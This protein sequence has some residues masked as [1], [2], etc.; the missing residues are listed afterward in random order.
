MRIL[1]STPTTAT[2]TATAIGL[3]Q[4]RKD[5]NYRS[6]INLTLAVTLTIFTIFESGMI[7][8]NTI[9]ARVCC[10]KLHEIELI[11]ALFEV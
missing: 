2:A 11:M 3:Q 10:F 5:P 1:R 9:I 6:G 8:V 7:F 4:T